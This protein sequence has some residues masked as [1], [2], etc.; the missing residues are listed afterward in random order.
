MATVD[1]LHAAVRAVLAGEPVVFAYL[2]GSRARGAARPGS[3]VDIAVMLEDSVPDEE[4]LRLTL[5]LGRLL[6]QAL[7]DDVDV[8]VLNNAPLRVVGRVLA[9]REVVFSADEPA[10]VRYETTTRPLV[11]DFEHH[12]R[13]LDR[14]FLAAHARRRR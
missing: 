13:A 7:R 10:R 12:A 8:Q 4:H 14:E 2:F 1:E 11:F 5:R 3:D 9:E 6:E